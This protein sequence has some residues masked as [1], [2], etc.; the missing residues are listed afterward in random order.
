VGLHGARVHQV[1]LGKHLETAEPLGPE[2]FLL[3]SSNK[4]SRDIRTGCCFAPFAAPAGGSGSVG[5]SWCSITA[6]EAGSAVASGG[7]PEPREVRNVSLGISRAS[8]KSVPVDMKES[9]PL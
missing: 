1:T 4:P 5:P 3:V 7:R 6:G 9:S 2:V 8:K